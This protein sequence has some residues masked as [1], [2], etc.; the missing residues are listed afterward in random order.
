M[1]NLLIPAICA[2]TLSVWPLSLSAH[3]SFVTH[4]DPSRTM[5]LRGTVVDFS[6]RSPHSFL[7]LEADNARGDA[8]TWEIE[9]ASIPL[10]A[11]FGI[12]ANT[13]RPGDQ[14]SVNVW[15]NRVDGNPLVWGQGFIT[16][17]GTALGEFPPTPEVESAYLA[18]EGVERLQGRWRVPVPMFDSAESPLPLTRAGFLA[19]QN[20]DPQRSPAN[21]C[22]PNN[23][24]ATYH[25]PYQFEINI[26]DGDV[27]IHQEMYSVTRAIRLDSEPQKAEST[28]V[29]GL[30][31]GRIE[32]DELVIESMGFP[33]SGWGLGTASDELGVGT[34]IPSSEQ[35]R[36]VE[37]FSVSEDGQTLIVRYVLEDSV[38]LT[39][40]YNGTAMLDRV[41]DDEPL[42]GYE[43][44]LDSAQRFS[45]DP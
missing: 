3:H 45:R 39:E 30:A 19:V 22:E 4:Y 18:A 2:V 23:V 43:C 5:E 38:Y 29:F 20:Y 36:L 32:S 6:L 15:P 17:D 28:G 1:R 10:L 14:V 35:K 16:A 33:A 7:Y 34:D 11:R 31:T 42:Y 44:E 9:M 24:P 37:R 8:I 25:S 26:E 13:F 12:S 40:P 27:V 41:A 21:R